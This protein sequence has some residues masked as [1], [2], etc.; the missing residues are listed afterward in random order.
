ML[1]DIAL[2]GADTFNDILYAQLLI[3]REYTGFSAVKDATLP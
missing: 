2:R 1:G 3:A